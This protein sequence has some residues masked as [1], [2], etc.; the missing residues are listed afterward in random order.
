VVLV[1]RRAADDRRSEAVPPEARVIDKDG[2]PADLLVCFASP[3]FLDTKE[4]E[5]L[6]LARCGACFFMFDSNQY[7]GPCY[8]K[9]HGHQIPSTREEHALALLELTHRVKKQYPNVLIE[10]HDFIT[11][12][13]GAHYTP[14]YY[15]FAGPIPSTAF[16]DKNSCGIRWTISYHKEPSACTTT[17]WP[18]A[19][20]SI[21]MSA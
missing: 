5:L 9:K 17:T 16:G 13:G 19:S 14:T 4:K 7:T 21:F 15:G 18:I 10:M 3:A 20:R 8:D 11:G 2:K 6:E 1:G 12:P